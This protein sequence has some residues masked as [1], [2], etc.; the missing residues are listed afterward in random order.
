MQPGIAALFRVAGRES[1]S[2]GAFDFGFALGP[3]INAAGRLADMT[4]GIECLLTDDAERAASIAA[5]LDAINRERRDIE[6]AMQ[7]DALAAI[8]AQRARVV[9]PGARAPA[10]IVLFD[11]TGTRAS[12]ASSPSRLKDRFH[13]PTIVFAIDADGTLRGSGR[14][15]A[16]FHLRDALDLVTKRQPGL[17]ARFGGHAMAAGLTI[18]RDDLARFEAAFETAVQALLDPAS[19]ARTIETDGSLDASEATIANVLALDAQV[20]GQG[21][22]APVFVDAFDVESQRIV[23]EKHLR[24]TLRRDRRVFDAIWFNR[25]ATLPDRAHVVYRLATNVY[26]GAAKI[27]FIVEDAE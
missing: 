4:L 16:G 15:I 26:N 21:F 23:K 18:A 25:V 7:D 17:I 27:Q 13:R 6:A 19:L 22:A 20:W 9:E 2:A 8:D 3:R 5:Q 10:T 24:L 14:S 1:R 11:E 12:S